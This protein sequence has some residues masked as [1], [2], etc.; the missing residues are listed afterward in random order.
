MRNKAIFF[1]LFLF[2]VRG[3][4]MYGQERYDV[5]YRFEQDTVNIVSGHTFSNKV[6]L[7]NLSPDTTTL[8]PDAQQ[9]NT[10]S[11]LLHLPETI[12]LA[13][14]EKKVFPLKYIADR[15]TIYENYQ[16][17]RL[18]F[19]EA[20]TSARKSLQ[21]T[22]S[23]YVRLNQAEKLLLETE[24][25]TYY[26]DRSSNQVQIMVRCVN[27]GL[28]PL[29]FRLNWSGT[30]EGLEFIGE[31]MPI[32][33]EP[34][35]QRLLVFT[36]GN[37]INKRALADY[38]VKLE[39][40]D[41]K[42]KPIAAKHIHITSL[43]NTQR[44]SY[45]NDPLGQRLTNAVA[46]RYQSISRGLSFY[47]L[48]GDGLASMASGG[49]IH[50]RLNLDYYNRFNGLNIYNSYLELRQPRWGIKLGNIY[51]DL[52]YVLN[53]RGAKATYALNDQ[54][55]LNLYGL[56]NQYLLFSNQPFNSS[57]GERILAS[58]WQFHIGK[59]NEGYIG[60]L[61][62]HDSFLGLNRHKL[63][64]LN[65]FIANEK[66]FLSVEAGYSSEKE[67]ATNRS[68]KKAYAMG[69]QY[70]LQWKKNQWI[71][72][73]YYSSPYYV[74]IR[75]GVFQ[76]ENRWIYRLNNKYNLSARISLLY[77]QPKY[78]GTSASFN[79]FEQESKINI[80]EIGFSGRNQHTQYEVRPYYM[81]QRV[82]RDVYVQEQY[83][84]QHWQS[85]SARA[86]VN[87]NYF[88]AVNSISVHTDYGYTY[89]NTSNTPMPP[90]HSLR[91]NASYVR[92]VWGFSGYLQLNPYYLS[93]LYALNNEEKYQI[94]SFGPNAHLDFFDQRLQIQAETA[95]SYYGFNGS[96]NYNLN[97]NM[98]WEFNHN[99]I[100]TADL[101]YTVLQNRLSTNIG[102]TAPI[103]INQYF[104]NRQIR[105]GIEKKFSGLQQRNGKNLRLH[106][107]ED[108][109][110][111]GLQ[112]EEEPDAQ[113][114][115]VK[116]NGKETVSDE[117]GQ[118][119]YRDLETGNYTIEVVHHGGWA[120]QQSLTVVVDKHKSIEVPLIQ[121]KVLRGKLLLIT[122][123]YEKN[124]PNLGGIRVEATNKQNKR[125]STLT[126]PQGRYHFYL[127]AD[128]YHV[129]ISN[130][131][132]PFSIVNEQEEINM[133]KKQS[134]YE[135]DFQY[136]DERRKISIQRF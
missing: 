12:K 17:F 113:G 1:G 24:R 112:D 99:W 38:Q 92:P 122:K 41:K 98:R 119:V 20:N 6:I 82:D 83:Q 107:F 51:E 23:F 135:L 19:H 84:N 56:Q 97:G 74:G 9:T 36:A 89:K 4:T 79:Y 108:H 116:I 33:L 18:S 71:T 45:S 123:N 125:Y 28:I 70:Q 77:N 131:G 7:N 2:F 40:I 32:T 76:S 81:E 103:F 75:R 111:N 61:H 48:Q 25:P 78:Q 67:I 46:I 65:T 95:Y 62:S 117:Q 49:N 43:S 128:V 121:T 101:F 100:L 129:T 34:G 109:N 35:S 130:E 93:D 134:I 8:Q 132:M 22:A 68:D 104:Y 63:S 26:L 55:Q 37:T 39:A 136:R 53:G 11:G 3:K 15:N 86:Q 54:N 66:Q 88:D 73:S 27:T 31:H 58:K 120:L 21:P 30:P 13:P 127:P 90:F 59:A 16:T 102:Q 115:I 85:A 126:D 50:Y 87:F 57:A 42:Q 106:Y 118:V 105:V 10:L 64:G 69:L 14:H 96:R 52:D 110:N 29:H 91:I 60:Y 94:Y 133:R 80:Y 124:L 114:L 47:Q 5:V 44:L 72:Q